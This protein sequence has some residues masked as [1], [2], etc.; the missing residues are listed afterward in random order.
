MPMPICFVYLQ[1]I[2]EDKKKTN[3]IDW[4]WN[5]TVQTMAPSIRLQ[6]QRMKNDTKIRW[7]NNQGVFNWIRNWDG[8]NIQDETQRVR[9]A[10]EAEI[11][12]DRVFS[13]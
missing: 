12:Y 9:L 2:V 13:L 8:I 10:I 11:R 1:N 6:N 7:L 4:I 5:D 3:K